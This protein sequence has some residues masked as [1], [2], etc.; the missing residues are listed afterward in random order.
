MVML[1]NGDA[2]GG[3]EYDNQAFVIIKNFIEMERGSMDRPCR[4]PCKCRAGARRRFRHPCACGRQAGLH[5]ARKVLHAPAL[6]GVI[7]TPHNGGCWIASCAR[8]QP[9]ARRLS[10]LSSRT[11][12]VPKET[13]GAT[14][15]GALPGTIDPPE[16]K[17]YRS[18]LNGRLAPSIVAALPLAGADNRPNACPMT[19]DFARKRMEHAT[20]GGGAHCCSGG[21][22]ARLE[23]RIML[24][25]WL[26]RLPELEVAP[27][28][29]IEFTSGITASV[30]ALPLVWDTASTIAHLV[31]QPVV[32]G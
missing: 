29:S 28:A 32:T 10:A 15:R 7:W 4:A 30:D 2:A 9:D 18:L 22:L 24:E 11:I 12:F 31:G 26:S 3:R 13:V 14:Y 16:H 23:I 20:F 17:P 19:V 25:E 5:E 21:H 6:P 27:G 1:F 8:D